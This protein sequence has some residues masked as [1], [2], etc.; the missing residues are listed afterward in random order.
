L[1][2]RDARGVA[3]VLRRLAR[4]R[5]AARAALLEAMA[6]ARYANLLDA[7]VAGASDPA[8]AGDADR[9][10]VDVVPDLVRRPWK[11]LNREVKRLDDD[12]PDE[13]LHKVRIRAKRC[14]YAAEA[15]A[16]V[17]GK[18]AKQL[19]KAVADLQTVLGDHQDAVVAEGWLRE[20]A[21]ASGVSALAAG[22]LISLQRAEAAASRD[23]WP[24]AWK[25]VRAAPHDWLS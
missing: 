4:Q 14:R 8:L 3:T 5:E 25:A 9:K 6:G 11:H 15:A 22:E 18:P 10:A 7:L 2:E 24:A 1:P 13:A 19:A 17:I 16:P 23:A 12:P 20:A 21:A